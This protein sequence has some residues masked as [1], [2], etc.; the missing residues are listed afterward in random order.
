MTE[1]E[2]GNINLKNNE[3]L[4]REVKEYTNEEGKRVTAFIP[5]GKDENAEENIFHG[6]VGIMTQRGPIEFSFD[7]P[8]GYDLKKCFDDFDNV[9]KKAL[10]E[11]QK[12]AREN[13]LIVTPGQVH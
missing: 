2:I 10:E 13:D 12:E 4:I 9:V 1:I 8:E 7:F 3:S 5:L 6:T 11:K